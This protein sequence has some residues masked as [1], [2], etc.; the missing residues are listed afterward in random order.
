MA[1]FDGNLA[2]LS[3]VGARV[4][5]WPVAHVREVMRRLPTETAPG[6]PPFVRGLSIVRGAPI[7]VIDVALLLGEAGSDPA[8]FVT[9]SCGDR[10]AVLAVDGVL[11]VRRL[12]DAALQSLPPLL[13]GADHEFVSQIG[14]LDDQ[15]LFVLDSARIVPD[16]AWATTSAPEPEAS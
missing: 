4:C 12:P 1:G 14:A 13:D 10:A 2:L 9:A 6:A 16:E 11:G 3:R 5:A 15:L 8:Y 7:P